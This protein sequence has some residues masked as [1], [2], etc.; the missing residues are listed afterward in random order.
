M[1]ALGM[2]GKVVLTSAAQSDVWSFGV[3]LW[4]LGTFAQIPYGGLS[5]TVSRAVKAIV[6]CAI[7]LD[8]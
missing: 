3:V 5:N 8:V 1:Y 7:V 2:I 6:W 4:E